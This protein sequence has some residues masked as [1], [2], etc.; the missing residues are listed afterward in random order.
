MHDCGVEWIF[1]KQQQ[2][3]FYLF[4][5]LDLVV[6]SSEYTVARKE[7]ANYFC[8]VHCKTENSS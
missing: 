8:T 7:I 6:Y 4:E 1:D 5:H 3:K 2:I